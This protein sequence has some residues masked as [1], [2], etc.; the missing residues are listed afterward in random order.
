MALIICPECGKEVSDKAAACIHCGFPFEKG[1][2][3]ST[4]P[5]SYKVTIPTCRDNKLAAVKIVCDVT[6]LS[7]V[8]AKNL[9]ESPSPVIV[10]DTTLDRA[11]EIADRFLKARIDAQIVDSNGTVLAEDAQKAVRCQNCGATSIATLA[12]GYSALWG[13]LGSGTPV[14]VCQSCGYKFKPGT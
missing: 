2:S 6:G 13:F 12:R 9:V 5:L 3:K 10:K 4:T 7:L 14:N 1:D 8:D 11:K